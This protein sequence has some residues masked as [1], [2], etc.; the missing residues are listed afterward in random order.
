[1]QTNFM[2]STTIIRSSMLRASL[3]CLAASLFFFYEF[4]LLN[5]FNAINP[6][7]MQSFQLNAAQLGE[8]S[9]Y[10]FLADCLFLLPAGILLDRFSTRKIILLAMGLSVIA[11]VIFAS[12][13][14]LWIAKC[15]RFIMGLTASFCFLSNLRLACRWFSARHL[16]LVIGLV[17][18]IAM[19][20]GMVAQTPMTLLTSY[21]GWRNALLLNSLMGVAIWVLIFSVVRDYPSAAL[22]QQEQQQRQ[23]IGFW[24]SLRRSLA[25]LQNWLAGLYTSL[26]NLPIFLLGAMW[27]GLYL[28]QIHH[29]SRTEAA[30]ITSFLF[31]GVIIGSPVIGWTSDYLGKRKLPMLVCGLLSILVVLPLIYLPQL[32]LVSGMCLY[33]ALGFLTSSQVIGYPVIAESNPPALTGTAGGIASTLIMAGGA[34]QPL[35]GWFMQ[36]HWD[37]TVINQVP[38]YA[39]SDYRLALWIMPM[40]F[41]LATIMTLLMKETCASSHNTE[42]L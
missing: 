22:Q 3:V 40:G 27:S 14:T 8:L 42:P 35:F 38:I 9:A 6:E 37:H 19:L 15:C 18:T 16:A 30:A 10:Y 26:M 2:P 24:I 1:M 5:M 20:G 7:L 12:T 29:L 11:S 32:S 39:L 34:A 31:V 13:H 21:L 33:F 4:V 28:T 36:R 17:V 41:L 25:N 23:E